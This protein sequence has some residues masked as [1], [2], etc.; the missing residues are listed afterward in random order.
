MGAASAADAATSPWV[1]GHNSR[2]R[3]ISGS[4]QAGI[5]LI[6]SKGWKTYWRMPGDAGVPPAFDWAGSTNVAKVEVLYPA[7]TRMVDQGGTAIGYKDSVIF[8]LAV[9]A[10][11]PA[12]PVA[13]ALA[14]EYGVCKDICIPAEAKLE[15]TLKS[16]QTNGHHGLR[17]PELERAIDAVPRAANALKPGDPR[18]TA[19]T[20]VAGG[21]SPR[22]SFDVRATGAADSVDLFAEGEVG[23][24]IPFAKR[25]VTPNGLV[26]FEI[27]L[28]KGVDVKDIVGKPLRITVT[29]AS[30][31]SEL[32]WVPK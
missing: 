12:Q 29:S 9:S 28:S 17:S 5:E 4:G 1:E 18:I 15:L 14:F 27:D 22:L 13:L 10:I 24:F 30:G 31:A 23:T 7:P 32:T 20:Y 26:H 21:P 11:D 2:V 19:L 16:G 25:S 3:L 8:P 6:M